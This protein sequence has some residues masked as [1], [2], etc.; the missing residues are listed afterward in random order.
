MSQSSTQMPNNQALKLPSFVNEK[1]VLILSI[2]IAG[3]CSIIYELLISTTS[4]YF[5]GDSVKQFSITIGVYMAAMGVG[6]FLSR[7]IQKDLLLK[8]IGVEILLGLIGGSSVPI[9]YLV[10]AYT[11]YANFSFIMLLLI[12]IIG[13]LTGLEIPLLARIMKHHYPLKVN[14]SNVLSLDYLGAL[15][16]TLL[17]PFVLLPLFGTFKSS[18]IFGLINIGVGYL[19][20]WYFSNFLSINKKRVS[21]LAAGTVTIFFVVML[22]FSNVLLSHWSNALFKDPIILNKQTPYQN[23][24]LTKGQDDLRLYLNGVIQFSSR[25]EYRYHESLVHIPMAVANNKKNVLILGGGEGLTAREVLKHE[26]V[27]RIVLVELDPEMFALAM[28][29][30]H[31][32]KLN[33]GSLEHPKVEKITQDAVVY[34]QESSEQFDLIISDL[35]D[36]TNESLSRL[37]SRAFFRLAKRHLKADGIFVTQSTSPYHA[38][39]AFWCIY[40]TIKNSDFAYSIP[41]HAYVPS[42]GD[43]GFVMASQQPI[44]ASDIHINVPT[45]F[46][47]DTISEQAFTFEKDLLVEN[48]QYNTLDQPK[49]LHYYLEEWRKWAKV[50]R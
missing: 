45:Q 15:L 24:I 48:I 12:L 22:L 36:P 14:L 2:F 5:L 3:L 4:S 34:L 43:W 13:I 44:E 19:N 49:L 9:L 42:F 25:D 18:L 26:E 16:A 21:Y 30:P 11:G 33:E 23:I 46:L 31:V 47:D 6:S 8:F 1:T 29:N 35:P 20:L 7:L 39:K 41:Y 38:Q 37:Y 32:F 10:Y 50:S 17:F 27:E 40:E 28:D